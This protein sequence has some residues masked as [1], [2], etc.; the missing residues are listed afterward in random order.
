MPDHVP[1]P[2]AVSLVT[3]SRKRRHLI[4]S[5]HQ[6]RELKGFKYASPCYPLETDG[7]VPLGRTPYGGMA[8][9]CPVAVDWA[10]TSRCSDRQ[11]FSVLG[12]DHKFYW[13]DCG[14]MLAPITLTGFDLGVWS[15]FG[16]CYFGNLISNSYC[17]GLIFVCMS[18]PLPGSLKG[19]YSCPAKPYGVKSYVSHPLHPFYTVFD[20]S[21][22]RQFTPSY[23]E[24]NPIGWLVSSPPA[25][26]RLVLLRYGILALVHPTA[27][28]R[29]IG[30]PL[31]APLLDH[32]SSELKELLNSSFKHI[33]S[34]S[35]TLIEHKDY[36]V[37]QL[38]HLPDP[39]PD[40]QHHMRSLVSGSEFIPRNPVIDAHPSILDDFNDHTKVVVPKTVHIAPEVVPKSHDASVKPTYNYVPPTKH[41][42][43]DDFLVKHP[44]TGVSSGGQQESLSLKQPSGESS[45]GYRWFGSSQA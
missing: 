11:K 32:A 22:L 29:H 26:Y 30:L 15:S 28:S 20:L 44:T 24:S 6:Y 45:I 5:Q 16:D 33:I 7:A 41:G 19:N 21:R 31:L 34:E 37:S 14:D 43:P 10:I 18:L 12:Y 4:P 9:N 3:Y 36:A 27:F 38:A 23:N 8:S 40:Y 42:I 2:L 25:Y 39:P 35:I 13:H 17:G 1:R